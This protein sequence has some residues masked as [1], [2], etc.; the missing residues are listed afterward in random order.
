MHETPIDETLDLRLMLRLY[1]KS[2][3]FQNNLRLI[4]ISIPINRVNASMHS[5]TL[6]I[7]QDDCRLGV[8]VVWWFP[9]I[10][11]ATSTDGCFFRSQ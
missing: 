8:C 4:A 5:L 6:G 9:A 10:D 3:S 2:M 7:K 1:L 11:A